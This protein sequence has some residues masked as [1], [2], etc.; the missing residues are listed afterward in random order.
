MLVTYTSRP[1]LDRSGSTQVSVWYTGIM[2]SKK[3]KGPHAFIGV[4]I[5]T[6]SRKKEGASLREVWFKQCW[7]TRFKFSPARARKRRSANCSMSNS[8]CRGVGFTNS[9]FC[10]KDTQAFV[11]R[12]VGRGGRPERPERHDSQFTIHVQEIHSDM[13]RDT[14]RI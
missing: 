9:G 13:G 2:E 7:Y 6:V 14:H 3:K 11:W 1:I 12:S 4:S 5:N 8:P 10:L